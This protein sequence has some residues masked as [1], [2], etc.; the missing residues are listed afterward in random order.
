MMNN[1]VNLLCDGH[2]NVMLNGQ[3]LNLRRA[4]N[5]FNHLADFIQRLFQFFTFSKLQTEL[6]IT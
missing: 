4:V 1:A 3:T 2:I 5:T 6:T